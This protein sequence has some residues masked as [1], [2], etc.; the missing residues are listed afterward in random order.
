MTRFRTHQS[1]FHNKV[2]F[3]GNEKFSDNRGD[4]NVRNNNYG[5]QFRNQN[6]GGHFDNRNYEKL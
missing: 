6:Y 5:N 3:C 2:S 1:P 4:K